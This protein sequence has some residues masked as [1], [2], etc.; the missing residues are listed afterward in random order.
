MTPDKRTPESDEL[1]TLN[2]DGLDAREMDER[3]LDS[4][5]GGCGPDGCH[6]FSE[7]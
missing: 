2:A 7:N 1:A 3:E 6:I 4:V 5:S